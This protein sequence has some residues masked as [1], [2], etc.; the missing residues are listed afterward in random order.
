MSQNEVKPWMTKA[1]AEI[2]DGEWICCQASATTIPILAGIIARNAP[3]EGA[4]DSVGSPQKPT[5]SST[6]ASLTWPVSSD[7]APD[8]EETG[9]HLWHDS[10]GEAPAAQKETAQT[11]S[12]IMP[13]T[14]EQEVHSILWAAAAITGDLILCFKAQ[15]ARETGETKKLTQKCIAWREDD[16]RRIKALIP[17]A[18]ERRDAAPAQSL[19][20]APPTVADAL[21]LL[22][23]IEGCSG[24]AAKLILLK[25]FH[26]AGRQEGWEAGRSEI[27]DLI[28]V[29][30]AAL[31]MDHPGRNVLALVYDRIRALTPS[32]EPQKEK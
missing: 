26:E 24:D 5:S 2:I 25:H 10:V 30:G 13:L 19:Y 8:R 3:A 4:P 12:G 6:S 14:Y 1:A 21:R 32:P 7:V 18:L 15:A 20:E 22:R 28:A 9:A 29:I 23:K 27:A 11:Q 31:T 16:L 17:Q